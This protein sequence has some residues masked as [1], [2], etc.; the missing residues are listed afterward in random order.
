MRQGQ[1]PWPLGGLGVMQWGLS[2][3]IPIP[4][5]SDHLTA[6]PLLVR[7]VAAGSVQPVGGALLAPS[8]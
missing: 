3:I 8:K 4:P 7:V 5:L 6:S 2:A 1:A